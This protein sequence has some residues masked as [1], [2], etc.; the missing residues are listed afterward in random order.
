MNFKCWKWRL[1]LLLLFEWATVILFC[2]LDS[3]LALSFFLSLLCVI[4]KHR[5]LLW[6]FT[7]F[8]FLVGLVLLCSVFD[9]R[10]YLCTYMYCAECKQIG[11]HV[12]VIVQHLNRVCMDTSVV[13][14]NNLINSRESTT[15]HLIEIKKKTKLET[16]V[17]RLSKM[18]KRHSHNACI[19][20][21][22]VCLLLLSFF[23]LFGTICDFDSEWDKLL[24]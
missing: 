4:W 6:E 10:I 2:S 21:P 14:Q 23:S 24:V 3:S 22:F 17:F 11:S 8:E 5:C 19:L 15:A 13:F 20:L 16:K 1:R 9:M 18:L 7:Y 12:E